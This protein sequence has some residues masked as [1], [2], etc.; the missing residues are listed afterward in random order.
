VPF[1]R[2]PSEAWDADKMYREDFAMAQPLR[3]SLF[4]RESGPLS[5]AVL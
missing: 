2:R 4:A 1:L 5:G 3:E